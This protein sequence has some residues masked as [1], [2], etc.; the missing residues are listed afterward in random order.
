[1]FLRLARAPSSLQ[2]APALRPPDMSLAYLA[3]ETQD[4]LRYALVVA[5]LVVS[6]GL[7]EMAHAWVALKC[8]DTTARDMGRLTPDPRAHIDPVMTL[9]LPAILLWTSGGRTCFGG[10]RPVPVNNARLR[11]PAR[12]MMFVA[13]AGPASN[14]L[15]AVVLTLAWKGAV[16]GGLFQPQD[17]G[18]WVLQMS[19]YFNLLLVAFNLVP[20]PPLD[21]SRVASFFLPASVR[22]TYN[23]FSTL[24]MLA[25]FAF[26]LS[27]PGQRLLGASIDWLYGLV[28][29]ITGGHWA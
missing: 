14:L 10:A 13:L 15:I 26:V 27:S 7:H 20:I 17:V 18:S 5:F 29:G 9:L 19:V 25:V 22:E 12:D 1:M 24:G 16:Y 2:N 28:D 11:N 3:I 6:L 8:G 21:G 23:S 4:L